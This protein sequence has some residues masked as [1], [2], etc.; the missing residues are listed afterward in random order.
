MDLPLL[1][2][3]RILLCENIILFKKILFFWLLYVICICYKKKN[4]NSKADGISALS[5]MLITD[6]QWGNWL[7]C[8]LDINFTNN[9]VIKLTM[10][11]YLSITTVITIFSKIR[12]KTAWRTALIVYNTPLL[13][14]FLLKFDSLRFCSVLFQ[15]RCS[16]IL[17]VYH[18]V[19]ND[20][21]KDSRVYFKTG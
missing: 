14:Y 7:H 1:S 21:L 10:S 8:L 9:R 5:H 19:L 2:G 6:R 18:G 12:N 17:N 15:G 4:L 11:Y 20:H 3:F 13:I 16:T